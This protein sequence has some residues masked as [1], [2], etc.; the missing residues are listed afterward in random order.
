MIGLCLMAVR[1]PVSPGAWL[2][3]LLAIN[4]AIVIPLTPG[5]LGVLEAAA[6]MSLGMMRVGNNEAFVF[7]LLYHGAHV[8]PMVLAGLPYLLGN[9]APPAAW[10]LPPVVGRKA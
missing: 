1:I 7:A 10:T 5:Q 6:V 4:L 2:L 3:V 9:R 8:V